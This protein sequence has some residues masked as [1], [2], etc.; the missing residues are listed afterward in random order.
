MQ[1]LP[2]GIQ[3]SEVLRSRGYLYV[4]KT[5]TIHRLVT[6]G[7][8]YFLAR[9]RRF[10]KSLLVSTLKCLFQG[11]RE[12]FAGLWIAAQRDWHWQ[13]HPVIVLDFNGIAHDSPQLLRTELTN[14]L[15]T[16][17]TKHQVSFEG[18]SIISQFRN[19]ILALH[20][21]TGQPVGVQM[22]PERGRS[23]TPNP[24]ARLPRTLPPP[25][26]RAPPLGA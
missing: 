8:Y 23:A 2:I 20:Q 21:Q 24:R 18:V 26:K 14:L 15:A 17:A 7:M 25:G 12:L 11:R 1:K 16:I 5:E 22:R 10:G 3:A 13:P 4:D 9:P 19:L 6:E